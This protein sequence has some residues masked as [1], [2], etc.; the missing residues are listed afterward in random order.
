MAKK[1]DPNSGRLPVQAWDEINVSHP[2]VEAPQRMEVT[3]K[4]SPEMK[5]ALKMMKKGK[6]NGK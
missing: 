2:R 5:K 3:M 6:K 4:M 1:T